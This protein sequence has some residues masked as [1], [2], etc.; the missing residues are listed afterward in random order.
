MI[1]EILLGVAGNLA[2]DALYH[3]ISLA[4]GPHSHDLQ[5]ALAAA[6]TEATR[7]LA[8]QAR[9][10]DVRQILEQLHTDALVL[11]PV[12]GATLPNA[13]LDALL[14][15]DETAL[16]QSFWSYLK[17]RVVGAPTDFYEAFDRRLPTE[18]VAAFG[19]VLRD[20]RYAHAWIAF[21]Q[22]LLQKTHQL[23]KEQMETLHGDWRQDSAE[24]LKRLEALAVAPD[25]LAQ[26]VVQVLS[27]AREGV[28][29][30]EQV[31]REQSEMLNEVIRTLEKV[32]Q[33]AE[34]RFIEDGKEVKYLRRRHDDD[35]LSELTSGAPFVG[36][37]GAMQRLTDFVRSGGYLLVTAPAGGGKSTLLAHWLRSIRQ[38]NGDLRLCYHF[39]TQRGA[40]DFNGG[41][42]CL[43]EQLLGAHGISGAVRESE[44]TQ[45]RTIM[46]ET[47][48]MRHPSRLVVILDGL[49]EARN[50][51][52]P[53]E[54]AI[55]QDLFPDVLGEG[56]AVIFA[57]RATEG[58]D[59]AALVRE[60][61]GLPQLK[62]FPLPE[63]DAAAVRDLLR[64]SD[65]ELLGT[66]A[67]EPEFVGRLLKKTGGLAIYLRHLTEELACTNEPDWE[68]IVDRLPGEFR[69]FVKQ[70]VSAVNAY[71]AWRD[72]FRF[73]AFAKSPLSDDDLRSLTE[74]A[75]NPLQPE[76][77]DA[78][79]WVVQ[80]WLERRRGNWAFQHTTIAEAYAESYLRD[81]QHERFLQHLL[82]YCARWREHKSPYAL[83]HYAEHL[84][85]I[86][87]WDDLYALSQDEAFAIAQRERLP[88]EPDLPLKIVQ[89]TLLGAAENDDA[90][91]MAE[92]LLT[93]ARR[94]AR[95]RAQES[96]LD[97]L[98]ADSL[99]RAWE[100][101]DLFEIERC[102]LWHLLLAWELKDT[103]RIAEARA[104]LERLRAK[105][106]PR[107]SPWKG[108]Y[109]AQLLVHA[110]GISEPLFNALHNQF[111]DS[112]GRAKALIAVAEAQMQVGQGEA[113]RA[114]LT[115]CSQAAQEIE[116]ESE[117][118]KVLGAMA[119]VQAQAVDLET[120]R[121]TFAVVLETAQGLRMEWERMW[122][123]VAVAQAQAQVGELASALETAQKIG[124]GSN[125]VQA[126]AAIAQAQAQ[127]GNRVVAE[128][129]LAAALEIARGIDETAGMRMEMEQVAALA[130]IAQ[131]Q[132][133][134]GG[135]EVA[136]ATFA[137]AL[138][139]T[140][141]MQPGLE[142]WAALTDIALARVQ[143]QV[144]AGKFDAALET[145]QG[146]DIF[147]KEA[148]VA[149]LATI[150]QAQAR[151]GGIDEAR[152][153]WATMIQ[154]MQ[155]MESGW[156]RSQ[157]LAAIAKVQAKVGDFNAALKTVQGIEPEWER[158]TALAD[159][160]AAR[161]QVRARAGEFVAALE[162]A[163]SGPFHKYLSG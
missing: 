142:K 155:G 112:E 91:A 153:T 45:L 44:P 99:K 72:A 16:R 107:L 26:A 150:A 43:S 138:Q 87:R 159:V 11:F 62:H 100:L 108:E 137:A 105:E 3:A 70:A 12:E 161:T 135:K 95:I 103:G 124:M 19:Q 139:I 116:R 48:A 117:R 131:A 79:P 58:Q 28:E 119:Q 1:A 152:A 56:T 22:K 42:A 69:K 38:R 71:P 66:K 149:A 147:E 162:M 158:A 41:L 4:S 104:T 63:L 109:A 97:A 34:G 25:Q 115:I 89:T 143:V 59:T 98:R 73:L 121:A 46:T 92:L 85:D 163:L 67:N 10:K 88:D 94:L 78:V 18:L 50:P 15:G 53:A 77:L 5:G 145:A 52:R 120:A 80:R 113:A 134:V 31:R 75:G 40:D 81:K 132:A 76:D 83:R 17:P 90:G 140:Q 54:F 21:Q 84:R 118:A 49:D 123:L 51:Q 8:E 82:D 36:R 127:A 60:Q 74:L 29:R 68:Q 33:L 64:L 39:F 57:A 14:T 35:F 23:F 151:A 37:E 102:V 20:D 129:T 101:A 114:T 7:R 93:H 148:R 136:E 47:L 128:A 157:A 130:A 24:T 141:W 30:V 32:R 156:G 86:K 106:L 96:P 160:E 61:L 133:Q 6:F 154:A 13:I 144:W 65:N 125:R 122:V 111:L 126:L 110:F 55:P 27:V 2:T 9:T 146:I